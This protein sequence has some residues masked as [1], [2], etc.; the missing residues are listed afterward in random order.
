MADLNLLDKQQYDIVPETLTPV[1]TAAAGRR[2]T[3]TVFICN[4]LDAEAR[5]RLSVAP[6]GAVDHVKHY[7]YYD[8]RLPANNSLKI[9]KDL[10]ELDVVRVYTSAASQISVT[11]EPGESIDLAT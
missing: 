10:N 11:V 5:F 1:Y 9:S 4:R 8:S 7:Y 3:V 6:G 2:I